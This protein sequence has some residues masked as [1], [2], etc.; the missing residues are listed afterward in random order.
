MATA[1]TT[2]IIA[3]YSEG[4]A[5]IN[6]Q[7]VDSGA[8]NTFTKTG[9][10]LLVVTNGSGGA[11]TGTITSLAGDPT[12]GEAVTKPLS[13]ASTKTGIFGPYPVGV[14]GAEPTITWS[15]G[16]SVTCAVVRLP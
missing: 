9:R 14:F 1:L 7:A 8:G 5:D 13:P 4:L 12:Y 15:T 2:A 16:T 11:L 10:E 6:P 3:G